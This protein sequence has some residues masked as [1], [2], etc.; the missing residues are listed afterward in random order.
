MITLTSKPCEIYCLIA[1][2]PQAATAGGLP[3]LSRFEVAQIVA[4]E[5]VIMTDQLVRVILSV[6]FQKVRK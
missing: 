4:C 1:G 6:S 5:R 2:Y 3:E